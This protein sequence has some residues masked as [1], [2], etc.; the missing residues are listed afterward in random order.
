V[1]DS[2]SGQDRLLTPACLRAPRAAV[3][4]AFGTPPPVV[5]EI[6]SGLTRLSPV[7]WCGPGRRLGRGG[8]PR[9][10]G[11]GP[12]H[13]TGRPPP[14]RRLRVW[15]AGARS[16]G[17]PE[18]PRTPLGMGLWSPTPAAPAPGGGPG[19]GLHL[20]SV[21]PGVP[22]DVNVLPGRVSGR[23]PGLMRGPTRGPGRRPGLRHGGRN[24]GGI[25]SH[26]W[27]GS[28]GF[29]ACSPGRLTPAVHRERF[30]NKRRLLVRPG[31]T[32][33][34]KRARR[35]SWPPRLPLLTPAATAPRDS[36]EPAFFPTTSPD[37]GKLGRGTR[38]PA[39]GGVAVSD[40]STAVLQGVLERAAAGDAEARRRL[41]ELTRD[42]LTGQPSRAEQREQIRYPTPPPRRSAMWY[43]QTSDTTLRIIP[44]VM[45]VPRRV[46]RCGVDCRADPIRAGVGGRIGSPRV[47]VRAHGYDSDHDVKGPGGTG[48]RSGD[49]AHRRRVRRSP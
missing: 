33:R 38:R 16:V 37:S 49:P 23:V 19:M 47:P 10:G 13:P 1:S 40:E 35:V 29:T 17:G 18:P 7:S 34:R 43:A 31:R 27:Y 4:L 3:A 39:R 24:P 14:A 26:R 5:A 30:D 36:A 12:R 28:K 22:V 11:R 44:T 8:W 2:C 6:R 21:L 9:S 45:P 42:R 25:P 41:L 48:G 20:G 46:V 32:S 15:G